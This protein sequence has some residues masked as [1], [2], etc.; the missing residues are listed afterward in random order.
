MARKD[1][2]DFIYIV[3]ELAWPGGGENIY[4]AEVESA[5][6]DHADGE[7]CLVPDIASAKKVSPLLNPV[8]HRQMSFANI[9]ANGYSGAKILLV[10]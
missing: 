2:D 10:C 5:I 7:H 8:M 4:C 9:T 6:F 1:E 3:T